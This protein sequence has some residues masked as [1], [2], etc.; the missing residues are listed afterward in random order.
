MTRFIDTPAAEAWIATGP[1][2]ETARAVM[3]AI[4]SLTADQDEAEAAWTGTAGTRGDAAHCPPRT[5]M[6]S[7]PRPG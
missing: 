4:A 3:R 2:R 5:T 1:S 7:R 6:S